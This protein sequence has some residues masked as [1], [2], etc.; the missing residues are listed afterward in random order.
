MRGQKLRTIHRRGMSQFD[1]SRQ[2]MSGV[3][4][5][6]TMFEAPGMLPVYSSPSMLSLPA[7]NQ[8]GGNL[9]TW[10]YARTGGSGEL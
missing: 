3:F 1:A 5:S 2:Y 7:H 8:L 4:D 6:G 9:T 10:P